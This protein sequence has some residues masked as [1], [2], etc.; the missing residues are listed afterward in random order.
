MSTTPDDDLET[1]EHEHDEDHRDD[2]W[3]ICA[4]GEYMRRVEKDDLYD[5]DE[6]RDERRG[7]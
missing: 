5:P 7:Y 1:E 3:W 2:G 6:E 4:C